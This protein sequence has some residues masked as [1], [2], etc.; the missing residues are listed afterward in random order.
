MGGRKEDSARIKEPRRPL[1]V[2]EESARHDT[3]L[4]EV[5]SSHRRKSSWGLRNDFVLGDSELSDLAILKQT[6]A[7]LNLSTRRPSFVA[8]RAQCVE[9][10]ENHALPKPQLGMDGGDR[11]TSERKER[12]DSA[13]EWLRNE[14]HEMRSQDQAL[15]RQLLTIRHDIHQLKLRRMSQEH[16]ELLDDVQSELE[17]LGE[18]PDVLDLP[19]DLLSDNPLKQI[20][21]TRMNL[22]TRRFSTC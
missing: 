18:L 19:V 14:L 12:I 15:A 2:I 20:G 5:P 16:R 17:E 4:Q 8:W 6:T 10:A 1:S 11:L 21:V 9:A 13:L 7:R 22:S 3:L